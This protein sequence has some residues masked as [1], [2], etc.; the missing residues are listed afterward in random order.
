MLFKIGSLVRYKT[1]KDPGLFRLKGNLTFIYGIIL[2]ISS[3]KSM[4]FKGNNIYSQN[5]YIIYWIT[6]P[7]S[8]LRFSQIFIDALSLKLIG[9][10]K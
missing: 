3:N 8:G 2:G 9:E 1:I 4:T 10:P 6:K 7:K 5:Y